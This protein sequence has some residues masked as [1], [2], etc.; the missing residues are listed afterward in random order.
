MQHFGFFCI[1]IID[2]I[3]NEIHENTFFLPHP[4]AAAFF[5]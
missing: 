5:L 3:K 4:L 2:T 1:Y